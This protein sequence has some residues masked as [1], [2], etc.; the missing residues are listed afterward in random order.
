[1]YNEDLADMGTH[2]TQLT[3]EV[4]EEIDKMLLDVC[5]SMLKQIK[6]S[7]HIIKNH[8]FETKEERERT[9]DE[10]IEEH[11]RM[12]NRAILHMSII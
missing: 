11:L 10:I 12:Q 2:E 4:S 9:E 1:M 3:D 5:R 7:D 6:R 8:L